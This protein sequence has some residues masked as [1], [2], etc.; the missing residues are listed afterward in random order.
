[1]L[2][3]VLIVVTVLAL[4]AIVEGLLSARGISRK[5][6]EARS[7]APVD[8]ETGLLNHR[9]YVQRITG[10]L[11]RAARMNGNLWLSV[12]TVVEG[13]AA[14]FGRIAADGVR[15]PEIGFRLSDRVYCFV[16]PSIDD[17]HRSD[18]LGRLTAAARRSRVAVGE[19]FWRASDGQT[20][21]RAILD[22]A[23][24]TME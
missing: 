13:D 12:W 9:A 5:I 10:E 11:K 20:T 1:M 2:S 18:M 4:L 17:E 16:R 14:Q 19:S 15:F 3:L 7:S 6:V 24:R 23:I 8:E 21:P 22:E